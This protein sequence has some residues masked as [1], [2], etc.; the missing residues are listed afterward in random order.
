MND[1]RPNVSTCVFGVFILCPC[2]LVE[3]QKCQNC[4]QSM[5]EIDFSMGWWPESPLPVVLQVLK[6]RNVLRKP[7]SSQE[8][9]RPF[10]AT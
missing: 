3:L 6:L 5:L 4:V 9:R 1:D 7:F 2:G 8:P 10:P